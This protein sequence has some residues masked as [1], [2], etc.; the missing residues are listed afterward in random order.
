MTG[1][2]RSRSIAERLWMGFAGLLVLLLAAGVIGWS[3]LRYLSAAVRDTIGG[4]QNDA[5]LA[6]RLSSDVAREVDAAGRLLESQGDSVAAEYRVLSENAHTIQH[7]MATHRDQSAVEVALLADVDAKLSQLEVKFS[8]AHVLHELGRSDA[9]VAERAAARPL[10]KAVLDDLDHLGQLKATRERDQSTRLGDDA[11]RR[12]VVFLAMI[13]AALVVSWLIVRTTIRGIALPLQQLLSHAQQLSDGNLTSRTTAALPG[14]FQTVAAALNRSAESLAKVVGVATVTAE[15]VAKSAQDLTTVAEQISNAASQTADSMGEMTAGATSQVEALTRIDALLK[16]VTERTTGVRSGVEEVTRMAADVATS[17]NAKREEVERALGILKDVRDTVQQAAAEVSA[18]TASTDDVNRFAGLVRG[19]A[20]QTNLLALNAAIEAARA[21][22]AGRGF[23][24]V[25]DE[26]RALA[27]QARQA[28][29]D[30][31]RTTGDV[32]AR[33]VGVSRAMEVGVTR[34]AEI[35]RV[36][37][38]IDAA[39]ASVSEFAGRTRAAA[40]GVTEAAVQSMSAVQEAASGLGSIARTA[41]GHAAAAQEVSASTQ[42]QSAACEQMTSASAELLDG[43]TQL[44]Q[45]VRTLR[46]A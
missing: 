45:I 41:E 29:E 19:I 12:A 11:A 42:E 28:A 32:S 43:S 5:Q 30:I 15:N 21:G 9:A 4:A 46:V 25:A 44:R 35:A 6:S 37:R 22:D 14:E 33:V 18:L 31:A 20:D 10:V 39:L 24:V 13:L 40:H 36:A 17:A 16:G 2:Q 27:T 23:R 1:S 26:V 34:V 8:L 7:Q 38:D 3:A